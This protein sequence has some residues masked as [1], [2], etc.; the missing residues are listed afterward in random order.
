MS[1]SSRASR[2]S[3]ID[4]LDRRD[5]CIHRV[6]SGDVPRGMDP[7]DVVCE[8]ASDSECPNRKNFRAGKSKTRG[9]R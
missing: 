7:E 4:W 9:S 8:C 6:K 5:K 3:Q 2:G 1:R